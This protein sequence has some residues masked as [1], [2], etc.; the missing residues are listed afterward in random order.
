M[1]MYHVLAK[2]GFQFLCVD[3]RLQNTVTYCWL[4]TYIKDNLY[5]VLIADYRFMFTDFV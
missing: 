5:G 1:S 4:Y 3:G 2:D